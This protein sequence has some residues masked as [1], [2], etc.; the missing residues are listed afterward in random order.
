[1]A[2][3]RDNMCPLTFQNAYAPVPPPALPRAGKPTAAVPLLRTAVKADEYWMPRELFVAC[4]VHKTTEFNKSQSS[5]KTQEGGHESDEKV[6]LQVRLVLLCVFW[7]GS[8]ETKLPVLMQVIHLRGYQHEREINTKPCARRSTLLLGWQQYPKVDSEVIGENLT[9][10]GTQKAAWC[11]RGQKC[12]Y[13][14]EIV[15][16]W[17]HHHHANSHIH[18]IQT[19]WPVRSSKAGGCWRENQTCSCLKDSGHSR[20][21]LC[22]CSPRA[23]GIITCM[24]TWTSE[25]NTTQ[26]SQVTC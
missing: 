8:C 20:H 16:E 5:W 25:D 15:C 24:Q 13:T 7:I 23:P 3:D 22:N 19:A 1:M 2:Y 6:K 4:A 17:L 14:Q 26:A 21:Q 11:S 18:P 12:F 9:R 10:R